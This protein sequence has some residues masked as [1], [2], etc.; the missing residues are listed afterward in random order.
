VAVDRPFP[1]LGPGCRAAAIPNCRSPSGKRGSTQRS[2]CQLVVCYPVLCMDSPEHSQWLAPRDE[3]D[4]SSYQ[5]TVLDFSI[6]QLQEV[7]LVGEPGEADTQPLISTVYAAY[8]PNK[9]VAGC[10]PDDE[11][12]GGLIPL[13]ADRPTR[14]IAGRPATCVK[15]TPAGTRRL[16]RR[17]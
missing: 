5:G 14:A 15:A 9:A 6:F 17:G 12:D 8:L 10:A 2:L 3:L 7:E 4:D 1:N 11:E 16:T 13:L